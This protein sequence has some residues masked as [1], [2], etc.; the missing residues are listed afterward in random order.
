M[1]QQNTVFTTA[2]FVLLTRLGWVACIGLCVCAQ[3]LAAGSRV[4]P[5]V[6]SCGQSCEHVGIVYSSTSVVCSEHSVCA[7]GLLSAALF[8]VVSGSAVC[9]C[10]LTGVVISPL[11]RA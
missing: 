1:I 8:F 4:G 5:V 10:S 7:A 9:A 6:G 2:A 3:R 11:R